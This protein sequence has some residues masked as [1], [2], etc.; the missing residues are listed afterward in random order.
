MVIEFLICL[1]IALVVFYFFLHKKE[2]FRDLSTMNNMECKKDYDNTNFNCPIEC[3]N[4][5]QVGDDRWGC[6]NY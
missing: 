1:I 6:R 3:P 5:R 2:N 4:K